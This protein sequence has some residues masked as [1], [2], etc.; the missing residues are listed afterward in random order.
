VGPG[1]LSQTE[2]GFNQLKLHNIHWWCLVLQWL[3][4]R[5]G[6]G[7]S[8]LSRPQLVRIDRQWCDG[9]PSST[10]RAGISPKPAHLNLLHSSW[11]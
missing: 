11:F 7:K 6:E 10:T 2:H 4:T 1:R 3:R 8:M 5:G 9:P